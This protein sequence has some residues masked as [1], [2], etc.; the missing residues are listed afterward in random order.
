MEFY[1]NDR[2]WEIKEVNSD[3]LLTEYKKENDKGTYCFGLTRYNEQVIYIN[4]ELH[5]D[6]KKQILY[7]ELMH[8]YLWNYVQNF[9]EV[10]EELLCDLS[11]NSHNMIHKI[12][13]SYFDL[14]EVLNDK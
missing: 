7:H 4:N 10:S 13:E 1:I 2:K 3:W 8:C 9:E 6:C 12:V 5:E 14:K 11:A